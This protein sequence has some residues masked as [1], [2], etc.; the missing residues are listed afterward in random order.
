M[1]C[2]P[3]RDYY[4]KGYESRSHVLYTK[5]RL[6]SKGIRTSFACSVHQSEIIIQR[7]TNLVRMFC[8]PKRDYYPKGYESRSHVLYTKARLL[9]KG[10]RISVLY[11]KARLVSKGIRIS[12]ACSLHQSE[13][14][15]QRDTNLC[16]VHQSEISIQRDTNLVRMFCTPKR[17]YYPKGYESRSHV[18]YTKARL[19]SKGIR[20]SFACSL[21]QSEISIQRDTNLCSVHQSEIIIQRDTN[22]VRMFCTPKRD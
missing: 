14:S 19:V 20:I 1:F 21:H 22:L 15:I 7:D 10:I 11:A 18:L 17:D 5:A 16:S 9:S 3:K 12:F 6:L 8:T 2:T 4:P 13:I